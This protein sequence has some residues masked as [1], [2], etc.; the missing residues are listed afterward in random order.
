MLIIE[1]YLNATKGYRFGDSG[2]YEPY[3]TDLKRLFRSMSKEYGRC[4]SSVYV[5]GENGKP[6]R[7]GWVFQGRVRYEDARESWPKD[8]QSYLRE[9][10]VTFLE[11]P[12]EVTRKAFPMNLDKRERS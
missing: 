5:D 1:D 7:V 11:R 8:E 4:V 3:T 2:P 6:I 10:W 12:D 9:V